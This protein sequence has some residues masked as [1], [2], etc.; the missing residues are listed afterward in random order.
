MVV[1]ILKKRKALTELEECETRRKRS[2]FK[3]RDGRPPELSIL[4]FIGLDLR[5]EVVALE[6]Q[7]GFGFPPYLLFP[8]EV[9]CPRR[10]KLTFLRESIQHKR[11]ALAMGLHKGTMTKWACSKD[12]AEQMLRDIEL[13]LA[14]YIE[15]VVEVKTLPQSLFYYAWLREGR[16][17]E[18]RVNDINT[19]PE[20]WQMIAFWLNYMDVKALSCVSTQFLCLL[21][22]FPPEMNKLMLLF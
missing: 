6:Q 19:L 22:S 1:E 17:E 20:I 7:L 16:P 5:S 10:E 3:Y 4:S 18:R 9:K 15:R 13:K 2:P 14:H 11:N 12:T 21:Y 8:P